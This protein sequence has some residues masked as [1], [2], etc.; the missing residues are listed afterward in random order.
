[1]PRHTE[2]PQ[3]RKYNGP[4]SDSDATVTSHPA[5]GQIGLIQRTGAQVLYGSDFIHRDTVALRIVTSEVK[6]DLSHDWYHGGKT[7]T[8]VEMSQAQFASLISSWNRGDGVPCTITVREG[9]SVPEIPEPVRRHE[10]FDRE[11]MH[12]L[13]KAETK[14]TAL[15]DTIKD[16][17]RIPKGVRDELWSEFLKIRNNLSPNVTHVGKSFAEHVERTTEHAKVEIEAHIAHAVQRLGLASLKELQAR[18]ED[19]EAPLRL[20]EGDRDGEA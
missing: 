14:L 1:M 13:E 17:K 9:K 10:Q 2:E 6:R 18:V 8:E 19:V 7:I 12:R 16:D 4:G 20:P 15:I 3:V 11:V 5:F